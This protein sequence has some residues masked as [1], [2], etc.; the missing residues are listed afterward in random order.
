MAKRTKPQANPA[1]PEPVAEQ[2]TPAR[3]TRKGI[4]NRDYALGDAEPS[5][6]PACQSTRRGR[7][8]RKNEI[9]HPGVD[10]RGRP[11]TVI[12]LRYCICGDCGTPRV[13]RSYENHPAVESAA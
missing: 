6:C 3:K 10:Q 8:Y 11:Y 1:T 7:Y 2:Q 13:D 9:N 12:Y 5:R 4:P